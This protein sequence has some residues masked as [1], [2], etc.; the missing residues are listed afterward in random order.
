MRA[1]NSS[2]ANEGHPNDCGSEGSQPKWDAEDAR[3]DRLRGRERHATTTQADDQRRRAAPT[4]EPRAKH[5]GS[6]A[7]HGDNGLQEPQSSRGAQPDRGGGQATRCRAD[8]DGAKQ[9]GSDGK[10]A[11]TKAPKKSGQKA[12]RT[13]TA[14][15]R[16]SADDSRDSRKRTSRTRPSL[17]GEGRDV[18]HWV[19]LSWQRVRSTRQ[20]ASVASEAVTITSLLR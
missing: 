14:L 16:R 10:P 9:D 17:A 15:T 20:Q 19:P 4:K 11:R 3:S 5:D 8:D 13:E 2:R 1:P 6:E 7:L 12:T 18:R